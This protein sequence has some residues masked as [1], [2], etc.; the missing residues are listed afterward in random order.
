MD[1][2]AT[3]EKRTFCSCSQPANPRSR[4]SAVKTHSYT[5]GSAASIHL[6]FGCARLERGRRACPSTGTLV[7]CDLSSSFLPPP[8]L[9]TNTSGNWP[10]GAGQS[11]PHK[12]DPRIQGND[13]TTA[14]G[15]CGPH[16]PGALPLRAGACPPQSPPPHPP[17]F[18]SPLKYLQ[19][20]FGRSGPCSL[21][22][23]HKRAAHLRPRT[24]PPRRRTKQKGRFR[25]HTDLAF[26]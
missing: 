7:W 26:R 12:R 24:Q 5:V 23:R 4:S 3:G 15:R 20:P 21:D 25:S 17:P 2:T 11:R 1:E 10:V 13:G 18:E 14:S 16:A 22:R 9:P 8:L 6:Q 19:I